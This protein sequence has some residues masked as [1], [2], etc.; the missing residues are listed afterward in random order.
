MLP[1]FALLIAAALLLSACDAG[2]YLGVG[3]G[4]GPGGISVSHT[5][6]GKVGRVN[7]GASL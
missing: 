7:V 4:V 2:P 6:S 5:V 1:R 3:L